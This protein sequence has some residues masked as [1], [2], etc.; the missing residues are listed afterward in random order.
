MLIASERKRRGYSQTELGRRI[1]LA[2][3]K[4]SEMESGKFSPGVSVALK[5]EELSEG[6]INAADL[7]ED[8]KASRHALLNSATAEPASIGQSHDLSSQ[9]AA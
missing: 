6:R 3:S 9:D 7:N 1:G 2:R 4:V 8:V 5:I